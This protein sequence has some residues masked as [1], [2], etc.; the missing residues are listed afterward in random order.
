MNGNFKDIQKVWIEFTR[1]LLRAWHNR[2]M[3]V[4]TDADDSIDDRTN[5]S[6]NDRSSDGGRGSE[7]GGHEQNNERTGNVDGPLPDGRNN[8]RVAERQGNDERDDEHD[9]GPHAMALIPTCLPVPISRSTRKRR[10]L[11]LC[12][13]DGTDGSAWS[14]EST[15]R[16]R[17]DGTSTLSV[18]DNPDAPFP[19]FSSVTIAQVAQPVQHVSCGIYCLVQA[20][21]FADGTHLFQKERSATPT[22]IKV[23]RL[24]IL[25]ELTVN[26]SSVERDAA[27]DWIA[28]EEIGKQV[29][30]YFRTIKLDTKATT[31]K[32]K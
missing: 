31:S 22:D 11:R 14:A 19:P 27:S 6:E 26:A 2:N 13:T 24:R 20:H 18:V 1:P 7:H 21:N 4:A 32:K 28:V 5:S 17:T 15:E 9:D 16:M 23:A 12:E 30:R 8:G 10:S 3:A 29:T 25:W